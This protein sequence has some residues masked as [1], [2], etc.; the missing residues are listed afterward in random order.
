MRVIEVCA[1]PAGGGGG[2]FNSLKGYAMIYLN[3]IINDFFFTRGVLV[4][5]KRPL[6]HT[7]ELPWNN[8]SQN[9][10]SNS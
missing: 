8:N 1:P 2:A 7:L 9:I 3:R 10:S 4:D 6:C 5:G